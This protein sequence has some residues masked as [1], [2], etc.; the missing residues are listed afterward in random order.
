MEKN[1][2]GILS[3][4]SAKIDVIRGLAI[5]FV[6][7][8]HGIHLLFSK[9]N[10]D[11]V[12]G[13]KIF[14]LIY[15]FHM[16]LFFMSSGF[17]YKGVNN[18]KLSELFLK[19]FISLYVPYLFINFLYQ[20]ER[21]IAG[22]MG[23]SLTQPQRSIIEFFVGD[24]YTFTWFLLSL[25][26]VK[27]TFYIFDKYMSETTTLI[28]YILIFWLAYHYNSI[29]I[30]SYLGWGIFYYIGYIIK[31]YSLDKITG[32]KRKIIV[33][34]CVNLAIIGFVSLEK[35]GLCSIVKIIVGIPVFLIF[36]LL[37]P[38]TP[39]IK[40]VDF[41]GEY[42]MVVY[43]IHGLS[44]YVCYMVLSKFTHSSFVLI[45]AMF[46]LPILLSYIICY[47]YS[48]YRIFKWIEFI[49]YPYKYIK[50]RER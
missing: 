37:L 18:K 5:I 38:N 7:L 29:L 32:E 15:S 16:P 45:I 17:L 22:Y 1:V 19:D 4:R 46:I 49:F 31:K 20:F 50:T 35:I 43:A 30:I 27:I 34:L 39:K 42:S 12:I 14:N 47:I 25:L 24:N 28:I 44:N 8:G 2:D 36:I 40:I 11:E 3:G 21:F 6:I 10:L 23:I 48:N 13:T 9:G 33:I 26:C 41:C